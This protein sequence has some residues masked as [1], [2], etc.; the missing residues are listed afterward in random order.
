MDIYGN[1]EGTGSQFYLGR[2]LVTIA[3]NGVG[4]FRT[5]VNGG[6]GGVPEIVATSTD[7]SSLFGGTSAFS[8]AM[9]T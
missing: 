9:A 6:L 7:A 5:I 8:N 3:A 4:T 2:V 1:R